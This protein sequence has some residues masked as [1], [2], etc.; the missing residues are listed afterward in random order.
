MNENEKNVTTEQEAQAETPP[1]KEITP[2][3]KLAERER[4]LAERER[5]IKVK[6]LKFQ[7]TDSLKAE[8]IPTELA[9]FLN[10]ESEETM[11]AGIEKLTEIIRK[12]YGK[13]TGMRVVNI[14]LDHGSSC[15]RGDDS[16][17]NGLKN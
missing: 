10:Y 12:R 17:L 7:A 3:E 9:D 6:E 1:E 5:A 13:S 8:G 16:F 4:V 11:T 2:E 14:G 15:S